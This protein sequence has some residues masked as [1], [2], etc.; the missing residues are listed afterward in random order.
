MRRDELR[1]ALKEVLLAKDSQNETSES[2]E[3]TTDGF[4]VVMSMLRTINDEVK[5]LKDSNRDLLNEVSQLRAQVTSLLDK[6]CPTCASNASATP[7]S[8]NGTSPSFADVV[9]Q[10]VQH[11]LQ[12]EQAKKDIVISKVAESE[13]DQQVV[14]DVC[15][16]LNSANRP[17]E[18]RRLGTKK[19]NRQRLLQVTFNSHFDA[20]TFRA[21]YEERRKSH[22][23]LPNWR[24][25]FGRTKEE[26]TLFTKTSDTVFKLNKNAKDAKLNE[27]Y[28]IRNDGSV[29]KFVMLENGSWKRDKD[30]ELKEETELNA[31]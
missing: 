7:S 4:D 20:R 6:S 1:E 19:E 3:S 14:D 9:R 29:W 24:L 23:D 15:E 17:V 8:A 27:S 26:Q 18:L 5:D 28:S 22:N 16:K 21:R 11:A 12:D 25:R 31:K 2:E 30:W 10:S 13:Q